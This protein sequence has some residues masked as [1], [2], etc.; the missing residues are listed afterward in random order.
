MKK[1]VTGSTGFIGSAIV[2][3]LIKD[4]EDVKSFDKKKRKRA[5]HATLIN[6]DVEKVYGDIRDV[7]SIEKGA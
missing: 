1:L 2:R 3:E 4:G 6:L 5:I 7:D